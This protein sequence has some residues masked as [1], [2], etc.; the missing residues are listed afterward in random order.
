MPPR[1]RAP[2]EK[3]G[4]EAPLAQLGSVTESGVGS[5]AR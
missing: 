3:P 1:Y 5:A 2:T 4:P